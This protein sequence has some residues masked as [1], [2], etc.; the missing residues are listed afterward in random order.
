MHVFVYEWATGGGLVDEPGSPPG[1]LLREGTAMVR[2]LAGDL[3][4]IDGC[5]VS[6]L[7]DMSV[8]D[9]GVPGAE[10]IDV[11]S[12][13]THW[14][15]F[16]RLAATADGTIVI[17]PEFDRILYR[18]AGR[19]VAGGG[20]L[21]SADPAFIRI[22]ANKHRTAERLAK[23]G[24]PV[25]DALLLEPDEKLPVAFTYPA[26]LKPIDGAGSQ[27]VQLVTGPHDT[28]LPY[29]WQ[30]RLEPYCAGM[31]A[32]VAVLCGAKVQV[33]LPP[34]E[35]LI[36]EDGRMRYL[37]GRLPLTEGLAERAKELA[38]RSLDALPAGIGYIGIDMVLGRDPAGGEDYVIE[39][40]PRLTTSYVGLRASAKG[41]LAEAMLAVSRGESPSI[42]FAE[43]G[44]EFDA[45]GHVSYA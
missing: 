42:E 21:L 20:T 19:V 30:R 2:A 9:L 6:I 24:V 23:A 36:S 10:I 8:L 18:T 22:A 16:E 32:S 40:N 39:V 13:V 37:G 3:A 29:A 17:A 43:R 34:C 31:A 45:E 41:N 5:R 28:P 1:S 4:R 44:L 7:R 15:E 33:A 27:D 11:H 12:S 25:P 14:E 26:V 38:L 35:Q